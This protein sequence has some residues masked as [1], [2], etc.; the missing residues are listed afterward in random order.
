MR[1]LS[2]QVLLTTILLL[3][4]SNLQSQVLAIT[5]EGDTVYIY[6]NGTWSYELKDDA[7][8]F[9]EF[10]YLNDKLEID[11]IEKKFKY[12]KGVDKDAKN[13]DDQ[14]VIKYNSKLWERVPA[15][16]LNEEAEFAFKSKTADIWSIIISEETE[17]EKDKLYKIAKKTMEDNSGTTAEVIKTQLR[18][19]NEAEVIRGVLKVD[20]AGIIFVFD[21]YYYSDENGS[22]QFT[23]WCGEKTWERKKDDISSFLNGFIV[24]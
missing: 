13:K 4:F 24:K 18:T 14:F 12:D 15:G 9:N 11:K 10:E 22:V 16:S 5:E 23:T 3:T 2:L 8:Y 19:V 17:I 1:I 20:F 7:P 6:N 21:S